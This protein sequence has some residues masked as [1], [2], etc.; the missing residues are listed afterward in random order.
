MN[1]P[2]YES[3]ADNGTD[4]IYNV[5]VGVRDGLDAAGGT[6]TAV[7]AMR[8][9]TITVTNVDE[10]GTV[11]LPATFTT[12]TAVTPMLT[13][14]DGT[15]TSVTWQWARAATANGTFAN[16]S[17]AHPYT[18]VAADA[19]N[20]LRATASYTD[21]EDSGKTA[22]A[23]SMSTVAGTNAAPAFS[24]TT[25]TR[26]LPENSGAGVNVVGG[27]ITAADADNDTLTYSLA[28]GG[29]N[30][31]FEIDSSGQIE[32]R[33]GVNHNF[34]FEATKKSY[35]VTVNV[36]DGKDAAGGTDTSTIDDSITVTINLTN[37]DEDGT[38]TISG[39]LSGG[40]TLTST[41]SDPDMGIADLSYKWARGETQSGTFTDIPSTNASTYTTVAADVGMYL[42]VTASYTDAEGSGKS[43]SAVTTSVISASNAVPTFEFGSLTRAVDENSPS[44]TSVGTPITASDSDSGDTLT[45]SLATTGDHL[46]FTIDTSSGQIKTKMGVT[47]N[48]EAPKNS[49]TVTV[50]VHDGKDSAG[51]TEMTPVVDASIPVTI[52]LRNVNEA[53]TVTGGPTTRSFAE[54]QPIAT[55]ISTYT[56]SDVDASDTLAWSVESA[57]DGGKFNIGAS[58]GVLTFKDSPNFEAPAQA[59]STDNEY[60]VTV[61]VTD[62]G[63][64][65]ATRTLTVTVT[66]VNEAPTIDSG[67]GSFSVDENT[68]T[69]TVIATYEASDVD[70]STTLTWSKEGNDAGDFVITKNA[71]GEGELKFANVPNYEIPADAGTNNMY[72]VTVKVSD[73]SLT[74]TQSVVVTVEDVNETPVVSGDAG[75][76]FAEIEFDV[77]DADLA[78]A[79]YVIAPTPQATKRMT[80]SSGP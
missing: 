73:G 27:T 10:P 59:G 56:A 43:A 47:Y 26:T 44:G 20:Y 62:A 24:S 3:P 37:V 39:T 18:P 21:P 72:D 76:S 29:D 2:N 58:S 77:E 11:T 35:T 79:D 63:G 9:V 74:D 48:F 15:P 54:N 16:I 46:S 55:A 52:N 40:S 4:N 17:T 70:A 67:P 7:D 71:A 45:Y 61:K 68:T 31:S 80:T 30:A 22:S 57:D 19:G 50:N 8:A 49:Y 28:S 69:A 66:N 41:F 53:P 42:Q 6:D 5:T 38:I 13:D 12:G 33:T 34:N 36:H 32:T 14:L 60:K 75:P 25:A 51:N 65:S 1:V 64:L 78:A 23:T